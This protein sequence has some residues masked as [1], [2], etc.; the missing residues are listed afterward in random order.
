MPIPEFI[1]E[2]RKKIGTDLMWLPSVAAVVL[3]DSTDNSVWACLLY[4]SPSPR[5]S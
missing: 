2:A 3:R 5:D 4:T 1:V